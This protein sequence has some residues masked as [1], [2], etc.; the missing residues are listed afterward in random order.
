MTTAMQEERLH[1]NFQ[2]YTVDNNPVMLPLGASSIGQTPEGY[3]ANVQPLHDYKRMIDDG[4][5][6]IG[7]TR[8]LTQEDILRR[9]VIEQIMCNM[10]VDLRALCREYGVSEDHFKAEE[11]KLQPLVEDD[12]CTLE[13]GV[14]TLPEEGRPLMRMVAATFDTYL[15]EGQKKHSPRGVIYSSVSGESAKA[16]KVKSKP[17]SLG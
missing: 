1:R 14:L 17:S 15:Q 9:A 11:E 16:P 3:V 10:K 4:I 8:G 6:P 13:N 12:I 2:G 7:R 5:L